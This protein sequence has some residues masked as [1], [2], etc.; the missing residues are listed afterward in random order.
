M[1]YDDMEVIMYKILAYLYK[2]NK[3]GKEPEFLD[4]CAGGAL[5]KTNQAYWNQIMKELIDLGYIR[6]FITRETKDGLLIQQNCPQVTFAGR[7]FMN[8]NSG[9]QKAKAFLGSAF[10]S[11]LTATVEA[12]VASAKM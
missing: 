1:A 11:I 8:E 3:A 7:T 6:G 5:I 10:E 9:M 12:L 4:Y 2:C